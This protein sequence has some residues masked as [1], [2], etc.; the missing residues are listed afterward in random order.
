MATVAMRVTPKPDEI[1]EIYIDESSQTNHRYLVLGGLGIKLT[2][3][4]NLSR[5]ISEARLPELP[6]GEAKWTRVSKSKLAAYKRIV[7]VL[8]KNLDA[9]T[10]RCSIINASTPA[11]EKSASSSQAIMATP[12]T[13]A[14]LPSAWCQ[15]RG[16]V[17]DAQSA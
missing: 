12:A 5:L 7:D 6:Q 10:P 4:V 9:V 2:S 8:F 3:E 11:I 13:P 15:L 1:A 16:T 14:L 17:F